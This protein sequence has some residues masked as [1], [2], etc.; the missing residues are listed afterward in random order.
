MTL[1]SAEE[2]S[3]ALVSQSTIMV[4]SRPTTRKVF[5]AHTSVLAGLSKKVKALIEMGSRTIEL[6][7][8]SPFGLESL[9]EIIYTGKLR[10][11]LNLRYYEV[12]QIWKAASDLGVEYVQNY[13]MREHPQISKW[14]QDEQK[15]AAAEEAAEY[16]EERLAGTQE[17]DDLVDM[18][19]A[20]P[21]VQNEEGERSGAT[22][23][24]IEDIHGRTTPVE[25]PVSEEGRNDADDSQKKDDST[26]YEITFSKS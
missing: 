2:D 13:I 8:V 14:I 7:D 1:I 21:V 24:K 4:A 20:V 9:L 5:K 15:K 3:P 25:F 11:G 6:K 18:C 22:S 19:G 17:S 12:H 10:P 23:V 26:F 16:M